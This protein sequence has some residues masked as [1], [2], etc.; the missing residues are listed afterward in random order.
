[1]K[2]ILFA[3]LFAC[4]LMIASSCKKDEPVKEKTY[5]DYVMEDYASLALR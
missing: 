1:M 2:R 4:G 3:A 5:Y